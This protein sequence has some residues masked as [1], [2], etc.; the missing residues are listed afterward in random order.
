MKLTE[1]KTKILN[2]CCIIIAAKEGGKLENVYQSVLLVMVGAVSGFFGS[3]GLDLLRENRHK[4]ELK[5]RIIEELN[6]IKKRAQIVVD[7]NTFVTFQYN[8][9]C[10]D[11]LKQELISKL[12]AVEYQTVLETYRLVKE[13][14][15]VEG[16]NFGMAASIEHNVV[17]HKEAIKSI[18]ETIKMLQ[19][20]AFS[21]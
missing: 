18:D 16:T 4:N 6:V 3:I 7:Q 13:I 11:V 1:P 21:D 9:D 8:T 12:R 14:R 19:K 2:S 20:G 10:F 17:R 5:R 15:S